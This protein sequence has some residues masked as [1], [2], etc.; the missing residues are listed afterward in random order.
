M[1]ILAPLLETPSRQKIDLPGT[2]KIKVHPILSRN[3][4]NIMGSTAI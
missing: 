1:A 3:E 4:K 2:T